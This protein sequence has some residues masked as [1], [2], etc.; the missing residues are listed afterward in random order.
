MNH[1]CCIEW[2]KDATLP[3]R[4]L[5][6]RVVVDEVPVDCG[7]R[8][9]LLTI[10]ADHRESPIQDRHGNATNGARHVPNRCNPATAT[11]TI[12]AATGKA[13]SAPAAG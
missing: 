12:C 5:P 11:G 1:Q 10:T 2:T 13:G 6:M 9:G 4:D 3:F 8:T 7:V